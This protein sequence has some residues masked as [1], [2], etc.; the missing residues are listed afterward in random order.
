MI[1]SH[2]CHCD[3]IM[4]PL[5]MSVLYFRE[6][7]FDFYGGGGGGLEDVFRPEYIFTLATRSSTYNRIYRPRYF[8][9]QNSVLDFFYKKSRLVG[10]LLLQ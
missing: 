7:P 3:V 6:R 2:A 10:L 1:S 5:D 8:F 4:L 9:G